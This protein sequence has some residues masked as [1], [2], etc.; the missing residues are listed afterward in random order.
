MNYGKMRLSKHQQEAER[1][2]SEMHKALVMKTTAT[3][4]KPYKQVQFKK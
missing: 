1:D 4:R 2:F 3:P